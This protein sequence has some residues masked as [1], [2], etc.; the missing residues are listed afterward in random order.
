MARK[1]MNFR[2][3]YSTSESHISG[4]QFAADLLCAAMPQKE[5]LSDE[6]HDIVGNIAAR[7]DEP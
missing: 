5:C 6:D 2:P 1:Q 3:R 7:W 4:N